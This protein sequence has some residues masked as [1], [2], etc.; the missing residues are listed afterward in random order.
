MRVMPVACLVAAVV[1][2]LGGIAVGDTA[3]TQVAP[4]TFPHPVLPGG[5]TPWV[6]V[7]MQVVAAMFLLALV[8]GPMVRRHGTRD[9]P[10]VTHAHDEPPGSSG[11]H[12]RTGTVDLAPPDRH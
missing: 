6:G 7:M 2:T 12:G 4:D 1:V 10:P 8:I 11:H 5:A 9:L 3:A